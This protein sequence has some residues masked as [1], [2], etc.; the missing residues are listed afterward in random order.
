MGTNPFRPQYSTVSRLAWLATN[1]GGCGLVYGAGTT[2]TR[3]TRPPASTSPGA[4]RR[5]VASFISQSTP[6]AYGY[7]ICQLG[8]SRSMLSWPQASRT[9]S[10]CSSKILRLIASSAICASSSRWSIAAFTSS[11][12]PCGERVAREPRCWPRMLVQ[13]A[14]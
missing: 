7:G 13:R 8:E 11:V 6:A 4:P 9:M 1:T 12:L 10:I 5:E 2:L 3:R 14:W